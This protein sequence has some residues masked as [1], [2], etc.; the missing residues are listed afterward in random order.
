MPAKRPAEPEKRIGPGRD[1][2][3][4]ESRMATIVFRCPIARVKV[5]AGIPEKPEGDG[6]CYEDVTCPAC[7]RLHYVNFKT[8]HVLGELDGDHA[9]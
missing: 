5:R 8:G 4:R 7:G 3:G 6:R 2:L 1:P 9:A